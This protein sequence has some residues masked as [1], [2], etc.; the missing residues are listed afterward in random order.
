MIL[1]ILVYTNKHKMAKY[2]QWKIMCGEMTYKETLYKLRPHNA[3]KKNTK[4]KQIKK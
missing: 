4:I 3:K 2:L 1:Q